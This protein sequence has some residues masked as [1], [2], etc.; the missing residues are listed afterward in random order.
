ML[1]WHDEAIVEIRAKSP[2]LFADSIQ[3]APP[4]LGWETREVFSR[5]PTILAVTSHLSATGAVPESGAASA[6]VHISQCMGSVSV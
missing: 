4:G 3:I 2:L 5:V 1:D 6:W